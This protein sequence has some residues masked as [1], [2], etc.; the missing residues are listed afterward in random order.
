MESASVRTESAKAR[1]VIL[2][3][4]DDG[5]ARKLR[6]RVLEREGFHVLEA[7]SGAE[8]LRLAA[9][10]HPALVLLDVQLPDMDGFAVCRHLKADP[11]TVHLPVLHISPVA[12]QQH[13]D[14]ARQCGS[15]G[16]L[17]VPVDASL[18][19]GSIA[20]L[21]DSRRDTGIS[22]DARSATSEMDAVF[23]AM[24]EGV[25]VVDA[26]GR[27]VRA[28]AAA[29]TIFG[30]DGAREFP[31]HMLQLQELVEFT[32]LDGKPLSSEEY[33]VRRS[34]AGQAVAGMELRVSSRN[35]G[36]SCVVSCSCGPVRDAA[37]A[38]THAVV[39]L[40]DITERAEGWR[41]LRSTEERYRQFFA[42]SSEGMCRWD[43]VPPLPLD[44]PQE[45]QARRIVES[46]RLRE[47]NRVFAKQ[48]SRGQPD[49]LRGQSIAELMP[50]GTMAQIEGALQFVRHGYR[51]E[52][53]D[54]REEDASGEPR[55]YLSNVVGVVRDG[56]LVGH[57]STHRDI[58]RLKLAEQALARSEA[59]LLLTME[60]ASLGTWTFEPGTAE[61]ALNPLA[62]RIHGLSEDAGAG[63]REVLAALHPDDRAR[64]AEL[65]AREPKWGDTAEMEA[66][67][68]WPDGTV[69]WL[70]Y[71]G[72]YAA[73]PVD[74]SVR[75]LGLVREVTTRKAAEEDLRHAE[76]G[77]RTLADAVP[78]LLLSSQ[79]G[80]RV[81]Y[82]NRS[83]SDFTGVPAEGLLN[84]GWQQVI[85][86]DDLEIAL[87]K[88]RAAIDT[89]TPVAMELRIRRAD[90]VYRW[91]KAHLVP[92]SGPQGKP[93]KWFGAVTEIENLKRQGEELER[94]RADLE[95]RNRTLRDS[96]RDLQRFA[97][98]VAHDLQSP[99]NA[100]SMCC[101]ELSN[102]PAHGAER[103]EYFSLIEHSAE[104]MRKLIRGVFEYAR[105]ERE[106]LVSSALVNCS[107]V[108]ARALAALAPVVKRTGAEV[109]S[110]RLPKVRAQAAHLDLL[111]QN[112]IG[113]AL[114]YCRAPV[115]PR[116][117][118]GASA[119]T[120]EWVFF[121]RDNGIGIAA[122]D[123][124]RLFKPFVRLHPA[125]E[126]EGAGMGLAIC[127][128]IVALYGGRI[129]VESE[130]SVGSTF[131]FTLPAGSG[132]A[133]EA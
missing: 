125:R 38:V 73:D 35:A 19:T 48:R 14:D 130:P 81:D 115:P 65:F 87:R 126:M 128:R 80:M 98:T 67:A 79:S 47:C 106:Q 8:A 2:N 129:W 93:V 61:F 90:G 9:A 124:G 111:F 39:N 27:I 56:M 1:T 33:P 20:T 32:W 133:N 25:V 43:V 58:T 83:A 28:N 51:I 110:E 78:S 5:I 116:I 26:S 94:K 85:H 4:D 104:R 64:V 100:I 6:T 44:L 22:A 101:H 34:L 63:P 86:P 7:E 3:V 54:V 42:M 37:G 57:W 68:V 45:T 18:L 23:D 119:G 11:R 60:S 71:F 91:M 108:F 49:A 40:H 13:G 120:S 123:L 31:A 17:Q 29:R 36:R 82:V 77:L 59:R 10:E 12:E 50:G 118:V 131:H 127:Q 72:R 99:L 16:Y 55:F 52:N 122:A 95:G 112:L 15:D 114:Q 75:W 21:I 113:N 24:V 70:S 102:A 103:E 117:H 105:L 62:R 66:R 88:L 92:M 69:H 84:M 97:A 109:T 121:V 74:G 46:S 41:R 30:L 76:Q 53:L 107:E 96:E 89:R 132:A